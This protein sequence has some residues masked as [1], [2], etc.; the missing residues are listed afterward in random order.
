CVL[1]QEAQQKSARITHRPARKPLSFHFFAVNIHDFLSLLLSQMSRLSNILYLILIAAL[2]TNNFTADNLFSSIEKKGNRWT[3]LDD[4]EEGSVYG[5]EGT[6][7]ARVCASYP[8]GQ[9]N[10]RSIFVA[11]NGS[12]VDLSKVQGAYAN[13]FYTA[14]DENPDV[15]GRLAGFWYQG[16]QYKIFYDDSLADPFLGYIARLE[17][18]TLPDIPINISAESTVTENDATLV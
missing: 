13:W 16:L 7:I 8:L 10:V 2:A 6:K 3:L 5:A 12:L 14:E 11:P 17:D 18:G 4:E 9:I 15:A 1:C